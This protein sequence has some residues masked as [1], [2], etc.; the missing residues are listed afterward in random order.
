MNTI[1]HIVEPDRLWLLWRSNAT[2]T[3]M[4][5]IVGEI[6][7]AENGMQAIL[8]Y[9][10]G[11][12]DFETAQHEGFKG[13][14][15]FKLSTIEHEQGV[16]DAFVRRLP[17]R[18]R[19][20]FSE[21]LD[22]HRLPSSPKFSDLA[23]LAYTGGKLPSDG[24]E[25]CADLD[26]ARP[27]FELVIE[28]AGFRYQGSASVSDLEIDAEVRLVPEP[29]NTF[30]ADAIAILYRDKRIGYVPRGL[31]STFRGWLNNGYEITAT[32]E[33]INGKPERPLIYLF[34]KVR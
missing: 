26:Q 10:N 19:D 28:I 33:R 16:L 12:S 3:S 14:P 1:E 5:L 15:S 9:R 24:F 32:I 11:T 8:R 18:S 20:D 22:R 34:V 7:R 30:D 21:Y 25:F 31:A 6:R 4:R 27:P 2:P 23:L 13:Y 29:E 17:P